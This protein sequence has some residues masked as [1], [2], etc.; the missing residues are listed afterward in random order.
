MTN[1]ELIAELQKLP[2]DVEIVIEGY[3]KVDA[4]A[5][6]RGIDEDL[7]CLLKPEYVEALTNDEFQTRVVIW[8]SLATGEEQQ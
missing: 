3:T 8:A 4:T 6:W 5:T 1:A 2:P 7:G